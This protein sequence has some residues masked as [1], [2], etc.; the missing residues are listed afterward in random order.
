MSNWYASKL[1]PLCNRTHFRLIL[2]LSINSR[3]SDGVQKVP[4][5]VICLPMSEVLRLF[6]MRSHLIIP[7]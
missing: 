3:Y 1:F 6:E 4:T 7:A 2:E 5:A